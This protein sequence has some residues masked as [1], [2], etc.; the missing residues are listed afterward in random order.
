MKH[1]FS[2]IFAAECLNIY[3]MITRLQQKKTNE[4]ATK[5]C[6]Y[7]DVMENPFYIFENIFQQIIPFAPLIVQDM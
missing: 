6:S 1:Y 3:S 4:L 7:F 2:Q 5:Q